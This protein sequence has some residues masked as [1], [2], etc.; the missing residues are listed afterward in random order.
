ML[1]VFSLVHGGRALRGVAGV[2]VR[3]NGRES[4]M[5]LR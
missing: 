5:F 3:R 1:L 4:D 2:H